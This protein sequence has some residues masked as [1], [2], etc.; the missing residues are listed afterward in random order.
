MPRRVTSMVRAATITTGL[1]H[2]LVL[3]L[4]AVP[5]ERHASFG[6]GAGLYQVGGISAPGHRAYDALVGSYARQR[7]TDRIA[8]L[9]GGGYDLV[10][11]W[12]EATDAIAS[13]VPFYLTPCF[14]TLDPASLLATSHYHDGLPEIPHEWLKVEYYEDDFKQMAD[15]AR[16]ERGIGT[17]YDATG[18]DVSRSAKYRVSMQPLGADQEVL[19]ALRTRSG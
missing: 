18:G 9:A 6:R 7:A 16:S 2:R 3:V 14:Y 8:E 13:A 17:L 10:T 19:A 11:F 1:E 5:R 15:V 4:A 12:R